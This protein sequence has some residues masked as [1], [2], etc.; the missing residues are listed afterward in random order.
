MTF[1]EG[2]GLTAQLLK[3]LIAY[4]LALPTGLALVAL[5]IGLTTKFRDQS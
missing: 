1:L 2:T 3:V 4:L 5:A